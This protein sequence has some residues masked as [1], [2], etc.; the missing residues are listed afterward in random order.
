MVA[1]AT[2]RARHAA[3]SPVHTSCHSRGSRWA[4]ST[5]CPT[6]RFPAS[7]PIPSAAANSAAA[8]SA[9]SGAPGPAI[10]TLRPWPNRS[11]RP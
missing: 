8:Y 1:S 9:T 11:G 2:R 5:A 3:N 10:G 4:S 7:G 6:Y